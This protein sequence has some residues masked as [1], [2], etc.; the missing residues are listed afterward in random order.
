M[1]ER[2]TVEDVREKRVERCY[3]VTGKSFTGERRGNFIQAT[4]VDSKGL[5]FESD[6]AQ[7]AVINA[8]DAVV[9]LKESLALGL[10]SPLQPLHQQPQG[11]AQSQQVLMMSSYAT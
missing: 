1:P 7:V 6:V 10:S 9:F 2:N 8:H 4:L 5:L 3:D 11:P